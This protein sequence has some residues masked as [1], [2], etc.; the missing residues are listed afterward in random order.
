MLSASSGLKH[1]PSV[2]RSGM[3]GYSRKNSWDSS[4]ELTSQSKANDE[5]AIFFPE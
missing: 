1:K 2:E 5:R 4:P 3:D